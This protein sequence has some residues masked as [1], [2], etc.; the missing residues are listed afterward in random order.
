MELGGLKSFLKAVKLVLLLSVEMV[1]L[2][3][4]KLRAGVCNAQHE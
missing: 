3:A 1:L 4:V 2:N